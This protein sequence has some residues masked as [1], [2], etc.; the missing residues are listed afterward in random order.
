MNVQDR[1]F[2]AK[3]SERMGR[4]ELAIL[5]NGVKGL[6]TRMDEREQW[7]RKHEKDHPGPRADCKTLIALWAASV[8]TAGVL[9]AGLTLLFKVLGWI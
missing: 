5:G 3:F 2:L 8:T 6:G 1:E 7:E 4:L 9:F